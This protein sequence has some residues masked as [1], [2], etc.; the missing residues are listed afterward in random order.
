MT[1]THTS[2]LLETPTHEHHQSVLYYF[3]LSLLRSNPTNIVQ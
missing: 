2:R 1:Y 3:F